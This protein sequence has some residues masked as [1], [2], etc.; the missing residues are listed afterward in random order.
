VEKII[1]N[2]NMPINKIQQTTTTPPPYQVSQPQ[3]KSYNPQQETITGNQFL[4]I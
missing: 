2:G 1:P 3:F 4:I